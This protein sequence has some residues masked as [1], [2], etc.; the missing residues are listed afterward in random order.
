M[1]IYLYI[2]IILYYEEL[3]KTY[4]WWWEVLNLKIIN[5]L[6]I[7]LPSIWAKKI[8]DILQYGIKQSI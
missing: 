5:N 6:K 2:I 1:Y 4:G 3:R 7:A 8:S